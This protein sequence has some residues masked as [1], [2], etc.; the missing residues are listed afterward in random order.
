MQKKI[1]EL[2]DI[3]VEI[4]MKQAK[5]ESYRNG[6]S[7][8]EL[9]NNWKQLKICEVGVSE[10]EDREKKIG[11]NLSKLDVNSIPIDSRSWTH[12][13]DKKHEEYFTKSH[14]NQIA[15]NQW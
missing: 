5:S 9:C 13:K 6:K 4:K 15:Q 3:A 8:H 2:E 7:I 10:G 1:S 11:Q 12:F 14:Y